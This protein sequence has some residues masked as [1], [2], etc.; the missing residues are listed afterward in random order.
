[1]APIKK[2]FEIAIIGGGIAGVALAISLV[3]RN[4]PCTI[5]EKAQAF[6]E[7]GAGLG[8]TPNA[9]RAMKACDPVIYQVFDRVAQ[10]DILWTFFDGSDEKKDDEPIFTLGDAEAGIR[11][12]HRAHFLDGMIQHLPKDVAK[13]NKQLDRVEEPYGPSGKLRMVFQDG[14]TAEADAIVGCDGI[15]SRTREIVVGSDHPSAT[16]GFTHKHCYRGLIPM[17]EALEII[18]K[19]RAMGSNLWWGLFDLGD[20]PV[21]TFSRGRICL[22]GDAAHASTPHQGAGAGLCIEDA[23]TLASSQQVGQDINAD[24][25]GIF[26][27]PGLYESIATF[28]PLVD[29]LK[30]AGYPSI[31][32]GTII[33]GG[34]SSKR[35]PRGLTI[36]DDTQGIRTELEPFVDR[37]GSD[38]VILVLHSAGGFIGAGAMKGL[39]QSAYEDEAKRGG[40]RQIVGI[41]AAFLPVGFEHRPL[42]FM[43]IDKGTQGPVDDMAF[44]NDMSAE[45]AKPWIDEFV[46]HP[47]HGW[48]TKIEYAGWHDVPV[49]YIICERDQIIPMQMQET[50]AAGAEAKVYRLD[51]GHMAQLSRTKELANLIVEAIRRMS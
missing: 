37:C 34:T 49:D 10:P 40:I 3:K 43:K 46:H 18:G 23:A 41:T 29:E 20:H 42:P 50:V 4:V 7:I 12:C 14:S 31:H 28:G 15:K 27:V 44:F 1:M 21:P 11:G 26:I 6:G 9:T 19:K 35:E 32:V 33:S 39:T 8:I 13:F 36:A 30:K 5:Y 24:S 17:D 51:A 25:K 22:I 2:D 16:C 38:G 48:G 45:A 47:A